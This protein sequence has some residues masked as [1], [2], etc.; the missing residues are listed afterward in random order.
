MGIPLTGP[1]FINVDNKLQ[2]TNSTEPDMSLRK[3]CNF[4]CYH[5]VQASVAMG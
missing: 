2:V 5:A 4:I 3:K 1:S